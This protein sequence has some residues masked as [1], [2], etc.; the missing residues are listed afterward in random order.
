[1]PERVVRTASK[2]INAIGSPG[3]GR[4]VTGDLPA[5]RR[6]QRV[7]T[8]LPCRAVPGLVPELAIAAIRDKVDAVATP[9]RCIGS[10][11][12][13]AAETLPGPPPVVP[14]VVPDGVVSASDEIV[15]AIRAPGHGGG[16]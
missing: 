10:R 6:P 15:D 13:V 5:W 4:W 1:M 16:I 12:Q 7:P 14:P 3:N 9:G 8:A 2:D 11:R